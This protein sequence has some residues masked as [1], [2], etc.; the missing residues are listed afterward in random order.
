MARVRPTGRFSRW[1]TTS[2]GIAE[3]DALGYN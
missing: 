1:R 2:S 3:I